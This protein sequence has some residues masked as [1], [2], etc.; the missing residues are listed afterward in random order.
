MDQAQYDLGINYQFGQGVAQDYAQAAKWWHKAADQGFAA[1]QHNLGACYANGQGVPQNDIEAYKWLS[2]AAAQEYELAPR[3][4]AWVSKRMARAEIV[5]GQRRAATFVAQKESPGH[6]E[7][8]AAKAQPRASGTAFFISDDGYLLSNFHVVKG[9]SRVTV[10]TSSGPLPATVVKTDPVNDIALLKVSGSFR[11]LPLAASR[12]G[13]LGDSVFTVG[14]PNIKLQG[15]EPKLTKGEISS[16]SGALD[17]PREFQ[18]SVAVQPGNSGGPLVNASGN[19]IGIVTARL[20]D[21]VAFKAT[22]ALPQ[23]VNY[24]MKISYA[25]LLLD[26]VPEL[27]RKLKASNPARERKFEDVVQQTRAAAALVLVY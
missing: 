10:Q 19:V 4:R 11:A 9:A 18:I 20:S 8:P 16:L 23:N 3:E 14:Y 27:S 15:I 22:G 5:E 26:S 25:L 17:D 21:T 1:A 6:S 2:L 7:D 13:K 24:A 12:E